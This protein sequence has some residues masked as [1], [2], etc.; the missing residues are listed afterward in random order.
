MEGYVK[1][2]LKK[3]SETE[4]N[5]F[6]VLSGTNVLSNMIRNMKKITLNTFKIVFDAGINV[7][8]WMLNNSDNC[9][10]PIDNRALKE[11]EYFTN[12]IKLCDS[13]GINM[14]LCTWQN[15][16]L[17]EVYASWCDRLT[18][19]HKLIIE[20]FIHLGVTCENM[21]RIKPDVAE[22]IESFKCKNIKP[23]RPTI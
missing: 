11:S 23:A 8:Q 10:I 5:E 15:K 9:F 17:L 2:L 14:S 19:Y 6:D 21:S 3:Y 22:F 16:T 1:E 7:D 4:L 20:C 12:I 18:K 13:K